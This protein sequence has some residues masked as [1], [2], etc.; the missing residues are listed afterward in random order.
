MGKMADA[1]KK[2]LEQNKFFAGV[3]PAVRRDTIYP[4]L[5]EALNFRAKRITLLADLEMDGDDVLKLDGLSVRD[6]RADGDGVIAFIPAVQALE[7]LESCAKVHDN[8]K[9]RALLKK[10]KTQ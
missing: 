5:S 1:L 3:D 10:E 2:R 7:F 9:K 6:D 4:M 8:L